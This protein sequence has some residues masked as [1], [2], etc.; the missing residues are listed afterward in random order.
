MINSF[1]SLFCKKSNKQIFYILKNGQ[2]RLER[3]TEMYIWGLLLFLW[4]NLLT[5]IDIQYAAIV[6][7]PPSIYPSICSFIHSLIL[8]RLILLRVREQVQA[9]VSPAMQFSATYRIKSTRKGWSSKKCYS[10]PNY[11]TPST[12]CICKNAPHCCN[13]LPSCVNIFLIHVCVSMSSS[14]FITIITWLFIFFGLS[15]K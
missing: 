2:L 13:S 7:Q 10:H 11:N 15:Y 14:L 1:N 5:N 6:F 3:K 9:T 8:Y 12:R 4:L